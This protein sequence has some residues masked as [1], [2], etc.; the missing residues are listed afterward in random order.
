MSRR[1]VTPSLRVFG[2]PVRDDARDLVI[3]VTYPLPW[4]SAVYVPMMFDRGGLGGYW[5]V[6]PR[7]FPLLV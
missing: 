2:M 4:R 3:K 6:L 5:V 7:F 1:N